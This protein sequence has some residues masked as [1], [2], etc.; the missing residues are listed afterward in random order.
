MPEPSTDSLLL[1]FSAAAGKLYRLDRAAVT[2]EAGRFF[3]DV[4]RQFQSEEG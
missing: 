4:L 2:R 3:L 1:A